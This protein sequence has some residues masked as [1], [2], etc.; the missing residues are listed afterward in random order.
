VT[1]AFEAR[2]SKVSSEGGTITVDSGAVIKAV[3][4]LTGVDLEPAKEGRYPI[5]PISKERVREFF[6]ASSSAASRKNPFVHVVW[7]DVDNVIH[8]ETDQ[9][10][11]TMDMI[12]WV[13]GSESMRE[14]RRMNL[15]GIEKKGEVWLEFKKEFPPVADRL[16]KYETVVSEISKKHKVSLGMLYFGLNEIASYR[17]QALIEPA[18]VASLSLERAVNLAVT[19]LEE[20]FFK[21]RQH[22]KRLADAWGYLPDR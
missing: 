9:I 7:I 13:Y 20:A 3:K 15:E 19:A 14:R 6:W 21:L 5:P 1:E 4:G 2:R 8:I 10:G 16:L 18:Q 22:Q 11:D 12:E 17:V